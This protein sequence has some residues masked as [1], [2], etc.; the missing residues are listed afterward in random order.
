MGM[1][2]LMSSLFFSGQCIIRKIIILMVK[3]RKQNIEPMFILLSYLFITKILK[4]QLIQ[5][6]I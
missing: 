4:L 3:N 5:L 2:N 6:T 1:N